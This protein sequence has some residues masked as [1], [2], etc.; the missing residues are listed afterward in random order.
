YS[1][2]RV[3]APTLPRCSLVRP[4]VSGLSPSYRERRRLMFR[5][6]GFFVVV[7]LAAL[8][9]A[10]SVLAQIESGTHGRPRI[11]QSIDEANRVALKGNT[12]P[13]AILANDRGPVP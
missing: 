7:V 2:A 11:V 6:L 12:R 10:S 8:A 1:L 9:A 4:G 3:G 13:E 5:S